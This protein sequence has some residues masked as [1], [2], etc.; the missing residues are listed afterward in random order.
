MEF[1]RKVKVMRAVRGISQAALAD[2]MG[3]YRNLVLWVETGR[4]IPTND[5]IQAIREALQWPESADVYLEAL[6]A[7]N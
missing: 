5:T 4:V 7:S 6:E 1:Q 3:Q 2:K